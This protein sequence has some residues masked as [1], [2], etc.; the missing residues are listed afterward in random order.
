MLRNAV[1][2]GIE[3]PERRA[4]LGKPDVGR[5][6][7]SLE[8]DGAEVV[9]VVADDGAGISVKLIREKA[10][11]LGLADPQAKL[12]DEEAVQLILEPGFSTAGHVTQAA[13][14]IL[15]SDCPSPWR[16]ARP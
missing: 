1:V 4:A 9:I 6:S 11:A 16:S 10:I 3:T 8:R 14:R 2:H 5:I 12:T 7:I 15:R 13:V